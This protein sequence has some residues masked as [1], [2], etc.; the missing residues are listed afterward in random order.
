MGEGGFELTQPKLSKTQILE[1]VSIVA[2]TP[3]KKLLKELSSKGFDGKVVP[4]VG[5]GEFTEAIIQTRNEALPEDTVRIYRG[6]HVTDSSILQQASYAMR[7][8]KDGQAVLAGEDAKQAVANLA[9]KPTYQNLLS[10]LESIHPYLSE[11][12]IG[13]R[14]DD[15]KRIEDAV[16]NGKSVRGALLN[17]QI[18]HTSGLPDVGISP[19]ISASWNA[20]NACGWSKPRTGALL[21]IDLP[22]S[23]LED[24]GVKWDETSIKT[25][26]DPR[27]ITAIIP[28]GNIDSYP[29]GDS[30]RVA[31]KTVD[32]AT[33]IEVRDRLEVNV[34]RIKQF[35]ERR[36][37]GRRW[38]KQDLKLVR[39]KRSAGLLRDF[40]ELGHSL[41]TLKQNP[42]G[43]EQDSSLQLQ[44]K[45]I[46]GS[47]LYTLQQLVELYATPRP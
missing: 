20:E 32:N 33:Q 43:S 31:L 46:T 10:Y 17:S 30:L 24:I 42:S 12:G 28:R 34:M 45:N 3:A 23:Q 25:V 26:L 11:S 41:Q 4:I 38:W 5:G 29:N 7:F 44:R 36:E 9:D 2:E 15:L 22:I 37:Q 6:V 27:Y 47:M 13:R 1:P 40:F 16:L 19:Y 14:E 39:Q 18:M 21:V 35:G 8:Y